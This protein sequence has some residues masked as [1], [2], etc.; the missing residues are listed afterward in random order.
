MASAVR[1]AEHAGRLRA[2]PAE[3]RGEFADA[4][5]TEPVRR[6]FVRIVGALLASRRGQA[7]TAPGTACD[8]L[9]QA[10]AEISLVI[11][12]GPHAEKRAN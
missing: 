11:R 10:G 5:G 9:H 3:R 2:D 6:P 12:M 4:V 7:D 1:Q 8:P